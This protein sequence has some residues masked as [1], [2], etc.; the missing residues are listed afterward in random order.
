MLLKKIL[1]FNGEANLNKKTL[2]PSEFK[3]FGIIRSSPSGLDYYYYIEVFFNDTIFVVTL[4]ANIQSN[5][6]IQN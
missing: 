2:P 3:W 6:F 4:P 5:R 1:W